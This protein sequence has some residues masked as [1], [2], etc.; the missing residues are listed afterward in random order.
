MDVSYEV[1]VG[2]DASHFISIQNTSSTRL[3]I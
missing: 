1:A 2:R 3:L